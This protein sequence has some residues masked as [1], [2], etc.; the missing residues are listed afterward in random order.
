MGVGLLRFIGLCFHHRRKTIRNNP[1]GVYG[2][3]AISMVGRRQAC[4]EQFTLAQF[5]KMYRRV[6]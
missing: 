4:A 2:K 3:E 6:N 1:A 5:A